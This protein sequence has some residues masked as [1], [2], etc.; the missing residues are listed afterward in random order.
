MHPAQTEMY[1]SEFIM[2]FTVGTSIRGVHTVPSNQ[3]RIIKPFWLRRRPNIT[4]AGN[5][6]EGYSYL[7]TN[8]LPKETNGRAVVCRKEYR[9]GLQAREH[10][11]IEL[12]AR[13]V[14][15][16]LYRQHIVFDYDVCQVQPV[17]GID[18]PS[19]FM[20]HGNGNRLGTTLLCAYFL[21]MEPC[22]VRNFRG[23]F[24]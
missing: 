18:D 24:V 23:H 2:S 5:E 14:M 6:Y 9:P 13:K 21:W 12:L 15:M 19:V 10:V 17:Y 4:F 8:V 20:I 16:G 3:Q 7:W 1:E 11:E 22:C